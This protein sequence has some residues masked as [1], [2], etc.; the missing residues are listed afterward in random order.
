MN[1]ECESAVR[2]AC[3]FAVM[4]ARPWD[5]KFEI[6]MDVEETFGIALPDARVS[7]LRTVGELH[8]CIVRFSGRISTRHRSRR[9]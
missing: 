7:E 3:G 8:E 9:L 6:V 2:A 1:D 4:L 5:S